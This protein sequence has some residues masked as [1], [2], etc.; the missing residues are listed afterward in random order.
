[1]FAVRGKLGKLS[2]YSCPTVPVVLSYRGSVVRDVLENV[3]GK[4]S[5]LDESK[6][7]FSI[8][9]QTTRVDTIRCILQTV[10]P[11]K[12]GE[13]RGNV[14]ENLLLTT[15]VFLLMDWGMNLLF[16]PNSQKPLSIGRENVTSL[17][18]TRK[19]HSP[20]AAKTPSDV[21][22]SLSYSQKP[23]YSPESDSERQFEK[24]YSAL[25]PEGRERSHPPPPPLLASKPP[26]LEKITLLR[27]RRKSTLLGPPSSE[28]E[29]P[30]SEIDA[31]FSRTGHSHTKR[32]SKERNSRRLRPANKKLEQK[33][34][35][36]S[37]SLL[38]L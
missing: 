21:K 37:H 13:R 28:I 29:P 32:L 15:V 34:R 24:T 17:H 16:A 36:V 4:N 2:E 22:S 5:L 10:R 31:P 3:G 38:F 30:S 33:C 35:P 25:L 19:T 8:R 12:F 27:N 18:R 26:K 1:M 9:R 20:S 14:V 7:V 6:R 23:H 11:N